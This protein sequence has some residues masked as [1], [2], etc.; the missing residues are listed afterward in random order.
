MIS[1][2]SNSN[3]SKYF[4]GF[5]FRNFSSLS[6]Y[7]CYC[8]FF[9]SLKILAASCDFRSFIYASV[10]SPLCFSGLDF[11]FSLICRSLTLFSTCSKL[12]N[13]ASFMACSS[14]FSAMLVSNSSSA[15]YS[16]RLDSRFFASDS[17]RRS[18]ASFFC[19]SR[20]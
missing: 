1:Y 9:S 10:I 19:S 12:S 5:S 13:P 14:F 2:F 4:F 3:D 11:R 18:A 20:L 17:L 7:N 16:A 8:L 15:S 6:Y